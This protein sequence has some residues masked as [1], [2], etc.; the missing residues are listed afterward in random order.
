M[1]ALLSTWQGRFKAFDHYVTTGQVRS[2][3]KS[4]NQDEPDSHKP[5][6]AL[7]PDWLCEGPHRIPDGSDHGDAVPAP[8]SSGLQKEDRRPSLV[9][10]PKSTLQYVLRPA[11]VGA[12]GKRAT[13]FSSSVAPFYLQKTAFSIGAFRHKIK[14]GIAPRCIR[15]GSECSDQT[16]RYPEALPRRRHWEP[17]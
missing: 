13:P 3:P 5:E 4:A 9:N 12:S 2:G 15:N 8:L 14:P 10:A 17:D 11:W 1:E 16:V 6:Y 7:L